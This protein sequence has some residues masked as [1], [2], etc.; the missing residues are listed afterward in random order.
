MPALEDKL[1]A[2]RRSLILGMELI[3]FKIQRRQQRRDIGIMPHQHGHLRQANAIGHQPLI[4]LFHHPPRDLAL[5][6]W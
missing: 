4:D 5:P 1:T 3:G 2:N 6:R